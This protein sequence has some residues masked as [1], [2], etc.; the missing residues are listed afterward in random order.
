LAIWWCCLINVRLSLCHFATWARHR[1]LS[2]FRVCAVALRKR[3][4]YLTEIHVE[5]L[6]VV[7]LLKMFPYR[8]LPFNCSY[9]CSSA[10][11]IGTK[12]S[13]NLCSGAAGSGTEGSTPNIPCLCFIVQI[14]ISM[15]LNFFKPHMCLLEVVFPFSEIFL[16]KG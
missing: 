2:R 7:T 11:G 4:Y 9:L 15:Q 3:R 12:R 8:I 5:D 1:V 10:A 6:I 16:P 14:H 13:P